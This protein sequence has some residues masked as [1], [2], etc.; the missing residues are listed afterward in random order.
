M[1]LTNCISNLSNRIPGSYSDIDVVV[2]GTGMN[3][4]E[5]NASALFGLSEAIM[6]SG[7]AKSLPTVIS[8]ARV[9][10]IKFQEETTGVMVDVSFECSSA[11]ATTHVRRQFH[12][13]SSLAVSIFPMKHPNFL[14]ISLFVTILSLTCLP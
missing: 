6:A 4:E 3:Y 9:P 2:F 14:L 11:L 13:F 12:V 7:M 5:P 1:P 10:I 8:S